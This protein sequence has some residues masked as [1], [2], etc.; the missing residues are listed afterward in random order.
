MLSRLGAKA[1]MGHKKLDWE[2]FSKASDFVFAYRLNEVSYRGILSQRPYRVGEVA[3]ADAPYARY[4][5]TV[6]VDDFE[7]LGLVDTPFGGDTEDLG[8]IHIP[9]Y[10][11]LECYVIREEVEDE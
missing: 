4:E 6:V 7:V 11:D 2:R 5:P 3:S 10:E 9:G 8:V 1:A